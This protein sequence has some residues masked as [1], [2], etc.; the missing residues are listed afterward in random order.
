M[1][2]LIQIIKGYLHLK[3]VEFTDLYEDATSIMFAEASVPD[4]V[5]VMNLHGEDIRTQ[6]ISKKGN[7]LTYIPLQRT[8]EPKTPKEFAE[9]LF[10][11]E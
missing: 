1:P 2:N 9:S 5:F 6:L 7:K 8:I 3:D 10:R 4:K 11:I